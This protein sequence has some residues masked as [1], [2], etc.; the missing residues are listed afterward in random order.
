MSGLYQVFYAG[1]IFLRVLTSAIFIYCI[2]TWL[3]PTF[4]A[5]YVLQDMI[6]PFVTP[7]AKL[8][9]KLAQYFR[10]PVDFSCLLALI[11]YH[12]IDRL[13]WVLYGILARRL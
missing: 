8:S 2:L 1:H 7:F 3:R 11:G 13:W 9:A 12:L 10:A 4:R 6:R 5:F